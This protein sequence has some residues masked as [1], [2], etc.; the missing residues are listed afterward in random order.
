M[1]PHF[2]PLLQ[3]ARKRYFQW[4]ASTHID[5]GTNMEY[6]VAGKSVRSALNKIQAWTESTR[7]H[8]E[9]MTNVFLKTPEKVWFWSDLH[10]NHH[11]IIKYANRPFHSAPDFNNE[12]LQQALAVVQPDDWLVFGGDLGMWNDMASIPDWM[13]AC[14]GKKLLIMGNHDIKTRG[15]PA[16]LQEWLDL[17]FCGVADIWVIPAKKQYWLTHYPIN[18]SLL[19][20]NVINV[21]GH[22]HEK[23]L[24]GPYIN[25]CVEHHQYAPFHL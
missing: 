25:M 24:E 23:S 5:P 18:P 3:A 6:P 8:W 15:G 16:N 22:I 10:L 14:P 7:D 1:D 12:L 2:N 17:G 9:D 20:P 4:L 19:L 11:N 21:H 13:K